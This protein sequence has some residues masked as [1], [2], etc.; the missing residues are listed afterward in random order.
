MDKNMPATPQSALPSK[1]IM[2]DIKAL[3]CTFDDT[4]RGTKKLL[5][6]NCITA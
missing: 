3:I 4:I 6:I 1:T 2:M 5:S